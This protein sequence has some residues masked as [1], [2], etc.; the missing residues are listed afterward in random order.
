MPIAVRPSKVG[1]QAEEN[2]CYELRR[3][4]RYLL[5]VRTYICM[6]ATDRKEERRLRRRSTHLGKGQRLEIAN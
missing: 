1:G 4:T 5:C 2:I 6:K 3:Y